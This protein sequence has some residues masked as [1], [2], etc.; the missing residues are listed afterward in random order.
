M[1]WTRRAVLTSALASTC[2]PRFARAAEPASSDEPLPPPRYQLAMN[3]ELMFPRGMAFEDRI[4]AAARCGARHYGFWGYQNKNLDRMLDVH[5]RLGMTCVSISGNPKT[6]WSSG[7]T[8]TGRE[9]AFLDDFEATCQVANRFGARN[10]IT[11]VGKLQKDIPWETQHANVVAGLK[12]AGEVARKYNVTLTLEPLNRVESPQM[13]M[14]TAGEAFDFAAAADHTHIKVDFDIYHRQLGEGN[15]LN[16]LADGLK[17]GLIGFIEVGDVPGRKEPGSGETNYANIFRFLRKAGYS[18]AIGM[19][20]G[21]TRTPQ[22][23]WDAVCRLAG[24]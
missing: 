3:L 1:P 24:L 18:G 19:E 11:F 2:L 12:K 6:G 9:Q 20:H 8:Q 5:H 22:Y 4:A 23:A 14:L 17:R 13:T 7:L 10:L 16:T 21:T 15:I